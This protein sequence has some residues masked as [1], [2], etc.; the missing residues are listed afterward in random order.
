M[1]VTTAPLVPF[2]AASESPSH[3]SAVDRVLRGKRS[4]EQGAVDGTC[5]KLKM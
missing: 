4:L 5:V 3:G 2:R 1:V